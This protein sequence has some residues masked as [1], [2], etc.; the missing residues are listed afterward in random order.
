MCSNQAWQR[1]VDTRDA[2]VWN[3]ESEVLLRNPENRLRAFVLSLLLG[4]LE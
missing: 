1:M 2:A 4:T 3:R